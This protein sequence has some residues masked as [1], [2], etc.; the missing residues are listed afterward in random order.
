M[1]LATINRNA[2]TIAPEL[3]RQANQAAQAHTFEEWKKRRATNTI[4]RAERELANFSQWLANIE[5]AAPLD[6]FSNPPAWQGVTWGLVKAF[7]QY[8]LQNGYAIG[9]V[10]LHL[11]TIKNFSKLA[12]A[13]GAMQ[14]ETLR[15]IQ[16]VQGYSRKEA[17]RI[18]EKRTGA[19]IQTRRGYKKADFIALSS[20][21]AAEIKR[22][23]ETATA[24]G[25]RDRVIL[26][27]FL[28]LGLRVGELAALTADNFDLDAGTVIFYREKVSKTQTHELNAE[29]LAAVR[30]YLATD[31]QGGKLALLRSSRRGGKLGH[32][33]MSTQAIS[34]RVR[35]YGRSI[36]ISN[37][38][39]HDLRHTWATLAAKNG[40]ELN[41]LVTAGGWTGYGR[42]LQY[43]ETATIANE[44]VKC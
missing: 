23:P 5:H 25:R 31:H 24:Q 15:L 9:T 7:T 30:D 35:F 27:I 6:L 2:L 39:A 4:R 38:S 20:V 1:T 12:T 44:G 16:L 10:N 13:A 18:D 19:Q 14:T 8:M 41:S 3:G 37:L 21:Q 32:Y 42:A 33:G 34:D 28:G 22:E 17:G 29:T 11:S 40:T 43:I 26:T 36:G